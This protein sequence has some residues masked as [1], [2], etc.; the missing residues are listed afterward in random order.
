MLLV[1]DWFSSSC[2][3]SQLLSRDVI[4]QSAVCGKIEMPYPDELPVETRIDRYLIVDSWQ[5]VHISTVAIDTA[6]DAGLPVIRAAWATVESTNPDRYFEHADFASAITRLQEKPVAFLNSVRETPLM[7]AA[8]ITKAADLGKVI[9]GNR[10]FQDWYPELYRKYSSIM[11]HGD[12]LTFHT[13]HPAL[14]STQLEPGLWQHSFTFGSNSAGESRLCV[15]C[16]DVLF[17][18]QRNA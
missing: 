12:T 4:L 5:L 14:S 10:R 2:L 9:S 13:Y 17:R 3:A 16:D 1:G 7:A 6:Y 11:L 15:P 18:A 8:A